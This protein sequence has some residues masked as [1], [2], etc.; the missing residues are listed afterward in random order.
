MTD[1]PKWSPRAW[2]PL[3]SLVAA[4]LVPLV[5]VYLW[6]WDLTDLLLLYW[7]ENAVIGLYTVLAIVVSWPDGR[8]AAAR[9]AA[10]LFAVPFFVVH[11]GMFWIVHGIFLMA[12]FGD[13]LVRMGDSPLSF[14][15]SP[16]RAAIDRSQV[17]AWPIAAMVVAHGVA[18]V[19]TFLAAGEFRTVGVA[20]LMQRP[21]GRVVVL[22]VT[23]VLGGFLAVLLGPSLAVLLLFVTVKIVADV[24]AYRRAQKRAADA[25]EVRAVAVP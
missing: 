10:K 24:A 5:G 14:F 7:L 1:E 6:G 22:H 25:V 4:N 12:F 13:G 15:V 2:W 20:Q 19:S 8:P 23:I 9:V 3:A 17:L 11:Y 16:I 21:Y 18:F